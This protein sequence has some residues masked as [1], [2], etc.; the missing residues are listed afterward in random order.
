VLLA[1]TQLAPPA[2]EPAAAAGR[3]RGSPGAKSAAGKEAAAAAARAAGAAGAAGP[4][5][6]EDNSVLSLLLQMLLL[7]PGAVG[8]SDWQG[9]YN[10][11]VEATLK[12]PSVLVGC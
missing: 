10:C 8:D 2:G 5:D 9:R 11:A 4:E 3:G 12:D 6:S 7:G 1:P